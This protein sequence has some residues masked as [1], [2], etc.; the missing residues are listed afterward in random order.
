MKRLFFDMFSKDVRILPRVSRSSDEEAVSS[1]ADPFI[2]AGP[3]YI[4]HSREDA[5]FL[6]DITLSSVCTS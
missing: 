5:N 4:T 2:P 6:M 3:A 1:P